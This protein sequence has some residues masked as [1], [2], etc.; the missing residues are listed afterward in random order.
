M[1]KKTQFGKKLQSSIDQRQR[2]EFR[3]CE[4]NGRC[5]GQQVA[6]EPTVEGPASCQPIPCPVALAHQQE[7]DSSQLRTGQLPAKFDKNRRR[8]EF[9]HH[10]PA[11][12]NILMQISMQMY[13]WT[14]RQQATLNSFAR[15]LFERCQ[16]H[17]CQHSGSKAWGPVTSQLLPAM[18]SLKPHREALYSL[19]L[20]CRNVRDLGVVP[21]EPSRPFVQGTAFL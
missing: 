9:F 19:F 2:G 17:R 16:G 12:V 11:G 20:H 10:W 14:N 4:T 3:G 5:S 8:I 7:F 21:A 18:Q 15:F 13:Y 1:T 6:G